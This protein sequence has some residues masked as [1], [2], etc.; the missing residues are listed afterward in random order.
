MDPD[1][2][3]GGEALANALLEKGCRIKKLVSTS[4]PN[5]LVRY[6][7]SGLDLTAL[8]LWPSSESGV[9][10]HSALQRVRA[11]QGFGGQH[12]SR[13]AEPPVQRHWFP[14]G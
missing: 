6:E 2:V 14:G 5:D 7:R 10:L 9:E 3:T 8:R 11:G 13:G 12:V 4:Y 1:F